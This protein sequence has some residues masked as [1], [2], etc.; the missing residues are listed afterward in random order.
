MTRHT[1]NTLIL[2][3]LFL[4]SL[5]FA[6]DS[7]IVNDPEVEAY[8]KEARQLVSFLETILNAVGGSDYTTK[9]KETVINE[10]FAKVFKDADVQIEDDLIENR[11]VITQKNVQAYL[12]D[13]DF[14]FREV[15]FSFT[16]DDIADEINDFGEMYLLVS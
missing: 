2:L 4:F 5:A 12:K 15:E 14:F 8:K 3:P 11:S 7:P 6:Q 1:I 16:I 10:S 9:Q 13:V